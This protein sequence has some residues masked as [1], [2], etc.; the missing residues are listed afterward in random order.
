[1][2]FVMKQGN[3]A[4]ENSGRFKKSV[5]FFYSIHEEKYIY[6]VTHFDLIVNFWIELKKLVNTGKI[7]PAHS[8]TDGEYLKFSELKVVQTSKS[9]AS[10]C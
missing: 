9:S 10:F 2:K 1:M 4:G 7:Y 5:F 8:L 3:L 6:C